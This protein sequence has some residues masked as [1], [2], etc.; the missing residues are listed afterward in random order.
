M[1]HPLLSAALRQRRWLVVVLWMCCGL[2]WAGDL[3]V[4][5]NGTEL[6]ATDIREL[7]LGEKEFSG[8]LRLVPVDNQSAQEAFLARVLAMNGERYTSLW[9]RKSFREGLNPPLVMTTDREVMSFVRQTPGAV[10]YVS[11]LPHD[12]EI[13]VVG[14][15]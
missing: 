14:K 1:G 10:G 13:H 11:S 7:Y 15:F 8:H 9:V 4:V 6:S 5:A 3:Y 12:R 2:A